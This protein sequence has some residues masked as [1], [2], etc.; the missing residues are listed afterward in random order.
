M[1]SF[2]MTCLG[3]LAGCPVAAVVDA[4]A[5]PSA[6]VLSAEGF[7]PCCCCSCAARLIGNTGK[8]AQRPAVHRRITPK[9]LRRLRRGT[10]H[11]VMLIY[12]TTNTFFFLTSI[13]L[14][15]KCNRHCVLD[16]STNHTCSVPGCS[17]N[18]RCW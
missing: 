8:K 17:R 5:A 4:C 1:S 10:P 13:S 15:S 14:S 9:Y 3:L 11:F 7:W 2:V 6:V 18:A 12:S 16:C